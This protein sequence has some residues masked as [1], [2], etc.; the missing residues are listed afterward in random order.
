MKW[1]IP[2]LLSLLLLAGCTGT[3]ST[4]RTEGPIPASAPAPA[5][6]PEPTSAPTPQGPFLRYSF[7]DQPDWQELTS[8]VMFEADLDQDGTAEPVSFTLRPDDE[9]A[10]AITW[11]EST[12]VVS[13]DELVEAMV[14]DLD[15]ASPF[16]NL[17]VIVDYGSD[18]CDTFELHPENGQ[19]TQGAEIFCRCSW[20]DDALWFSEMTDFL[21]SAGGKR[22]YSGDDL[23]P[24]SE[25]ITMTYIPTAEELETERED[26]IEYWLRHTVRPVPCTIDGKPGMIPADT[27]LYP[28][29]IRDDEQL[30]EVALLDGTV[31]QIA[32]TVEDW[33][34]YID[35]LEQ[36]EYF[37]NLIFAD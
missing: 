7:Y 31:A 27:Y 20:H 11:G 26:L 6:I 16:Y 21:G 10:T 25:W 33:Y 34:Y 32:C 19:L 17:L 8:G 28:L 29:R 4:S 23:S 24:D 12:V 15:P 5:S 2:L 3:P 13:S 22:T 14:L 1:I 36:Q 18:S 30:A 35:G 9:W 37:D